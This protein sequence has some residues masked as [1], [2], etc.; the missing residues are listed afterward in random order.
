MPTIDQRPNHVLQL[1]AARERAAADA[2]GYDAAAHH[3]ACCRI[4]EILEARRLGLAR[5]VKS[6]RVKV[7]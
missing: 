1:M 3:R 7:L 6:L 4:V 5:Q 2:L